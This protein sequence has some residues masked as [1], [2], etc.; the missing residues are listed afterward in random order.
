MVCSALCTLK[1]RLLESSTRSIYCTSTHTKAGLNYRRLF[2]GIFFD[3][4]HTRAVACLLLLRLY[5]CLAYARNATCTRHDDD[6]DDVELVLLLMGGKGR[7]TALLRKSSHFMCS[8]K[9]VCVV[10]IASLCPL[11]IVFDAYNKIPPSSC[12]RRA[13]RTQH[14]NWFQRI[15]PT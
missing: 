4:L 13:R 6:D 5:L 9:D 2:F 12:V 3:E 1:S 10:Y 7:T 11:K 8:K 15:D 14:I